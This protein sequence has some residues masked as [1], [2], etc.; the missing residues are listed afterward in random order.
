MTF[1]ELNFSMTSLIQKSHFFVIN[2]NTHRNS[3][4][5]TCNSRYIW[6]VKDGYILALRTRL[7][8]LKFIVRGIWKS[9]MMWKLLLDFDIFQITCNCWSFFWHRNR[10]HQLKIISCKCDM[11]PSRWC[12]RTVI[13]RDNIKPEKIK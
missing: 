3:A 4:N 7:S 2:I 8:A 12:F 5:Q 1:F 10:F 11:K 9:S 13:H 6:T